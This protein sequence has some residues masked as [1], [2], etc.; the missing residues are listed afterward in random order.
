MGHADTRMVE[1][2]YARTRHEGVMKHRKT[3]ETLNSEYRIGSNVAPE[4]L[5]KPRNI[6]TF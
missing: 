2:T 4:N 1:T 6:N 5:K 3:L